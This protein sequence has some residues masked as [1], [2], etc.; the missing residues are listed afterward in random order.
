MIR[1]I[2]AT[3]L[4]SFVM[5]GLHIAIAGDH[6]NLEEGI[7]VQVEDAFP[8]GYQGRELQA[9]TQYERTDE[10]KNR[11]TVVPRLEYGFAM[12]WQA[13]VEAPFYFGS[14]EKTG[15]GDVVVSALY[16]F[17]TETTLFPAVAA[18]GALELPSG[19]DSSGVDSHLKLVLSKTLSRSSF[20]H[21][22]HLNLEWRHNANASSNERTDRYQAVLGYQLRL[23]PNNQLLLDLSREQEV[24]TEHT[25]N[26]IEVGLRHQWDP[27]TV[28]SVGAGVGIGQQSPDIRCTLGL[29][30]ALNLIH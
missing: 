6:L 16:N 8:I 29:Q 23:G 30:R 1:K 7:P 22:L 10:G 15:S 19:S 20:F 13:E 9:Y 25:S 5:P 17:N 12:N 3:V 21:R 14:A 4:L 11:F 28:L 26:V 2:A 18:K 24:R 27:L